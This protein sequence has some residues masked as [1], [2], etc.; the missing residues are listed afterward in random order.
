[1]NP[2]HTIR[3]AGPADVPRLVEMNHAAYPDLVAEGIVFDG[4]QLAA[5]QAVFP[6]GQ[7]VLVDASGAIV[8]ALSTLIVS[9][10]EALA[11][12]TWIDIT[13]HGSFAKHDPRGDTLYLADI[14]SDPLARGTGTGAALY[15][16]LFAL[17]RRKNLARVAAGGRLYGY[18]D[19]AKELSA[20]DYVEEVL[21]GER[22][23]RVLTSQV[24]AGFVVKDV[25]SNY[26]DDW[27][28]GSFATLLVWENPDYKTTPQ[29]VG[30]SLASAHRDARPT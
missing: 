4:A 17:C 6:D 10:A 5:H 8:G 24:R 7:L 20:A 26:L 12:H 2:K 13:S 14:Y 11:A 19:V 21:R 3:R 22:K 28:S 18:S 1:M 29:Q 9:S 27:R 15:D 23:D 16:A 25:L 30:A